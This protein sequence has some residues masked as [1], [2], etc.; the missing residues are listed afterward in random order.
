MISLT[1]TTGL[2]IYTI[3]EIAIIALV[4]FLV[5]LFYHRMKNIDENTRKTNEILSEIR[6]EINDKSHGRQD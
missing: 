2:A 5:V 4:I 3:L 1:G 6:D